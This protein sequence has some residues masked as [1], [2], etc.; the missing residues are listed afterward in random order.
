MSQNNILSSTLYANVPGAENI[1]VFLR[2]LL[3]AQG[4]YEPKFS[5]E[6]VNKYLLELAEVFEQYLAT[7]L[8]AK[9]SDEQAEKLSTMNQNASIEEQARFLS[10][11]LPDL[12]NKMLEILTEFSEIYLG[13]KKE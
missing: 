13:L 3:K 8:V 12:Q 4:I 9:L 1:E 7:A 10:A 6:E 2:Q 5:A 11:V